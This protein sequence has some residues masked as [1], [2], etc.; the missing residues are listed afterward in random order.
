VQQ[1]IASDAQL[2]QPNN[3]D[4]GAGV[5][6]P[7]RITPSEPLTSGATTTENESGM[8]PCQRTPAVPRGEVG[9]GVVI[10]GDVR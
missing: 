9:I 3:D 7:D 10:P 4:L 2:M 5:A 8:V 6:T 1:P